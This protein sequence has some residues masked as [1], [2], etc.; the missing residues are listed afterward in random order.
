MSTRKVK[1]RGRAEVA[2]GTLALR[3][4]KPAG[5][6]FK[7]G[8]AMDVIL[9]DGEAHAFSIV[10]APYEDELA[11]ATRLRDTTYKR[12]LASLGEGDTGSLD[13]PFGSLTLHKDAARPAIFVAGGIGITPFM[14]ILRQAARERAQRDLVLVYSNRSPGDAAFLDELVELGR[15]HPRIR[16]VATMT[17]AQGSSWRGETRFVGADLLREVG[18]G[19]ANPVW[20]VAGPPGMVRAT[21][22]ALESQGVDDEDLRVEEFTGYPAA[23]PVPA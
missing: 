2:R 21:R 1:V 4:E 6:A 20:Y 23:A 3:L 8:Q 11:V 18:A 16:V 19:L 14:S 10:S 12:A 5:F 13:G 15:R 7:A 17:E 9:A 22:A